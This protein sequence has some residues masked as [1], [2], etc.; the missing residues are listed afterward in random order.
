MMRDQYPYFDQP[1]PIYLDSAATG[2]MPRATLTTLTDYY[3]NPA[4]VGRSNYPRAGEITAQFTAARKIIAQF[5]NASPD[6]IIFTHSTTASINYIARFLLPTISTQH[7]IVITDHEHNSNYLPWVNLSHDTGAK[8][9]LIHNDTATIHPNTKIF[10]YALADNVA[11]RQHTFPNIVKQV[12]E[13]NGVVVVDA[14]QAIAKQPI[15]VKR[16]A[17][18]ALAFSGHKLGAPTGCGVLYIKRA[19]QQ[20]LTPLFYGSETFQAI[21]TK[22]HTFQLR[23]DPSKFEPGTPH[24][25]GILGLAAT[26]NL[27]NQIGWPKITAHYAK[28][29]H[30]ATEQIRAGG[31]ANHLLDQVG[32]AI[33]LAHP[34]AS[35]H[36]IALLL[37]D[38]YRINVRSGLLC[39]QLYFDTHNLPAGA[40]R[41]SFGLYTTEEEIRNFITSYQRCLKELLCC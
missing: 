30:Y 35:P 18:D 16:L 28:L 29:A 33:A 25:A 32:G 40:V 1:R 41:A 5:I 6:E 22:Q 34:K 20:H 36:D 13:L 9:Q 21:N 12:H 31:L 17:C 2:L 7:R 11:I 38:R 26:I 39:N 8:L 10:S 4:N 27:I 15:D 14:A 24:I 19:L 23:A 3:T 37:A